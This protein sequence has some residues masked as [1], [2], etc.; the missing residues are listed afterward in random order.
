[1]VKDLP[2]MELFNPQ[3]Y[4]GGSWSYFFLSQCIRQLMQDPTETLDAGTHSTWNVCPS[5]PRP[6]KQS[7]FRPALR[8]MLSLL[9]SSVRTAQGRSVFYSSA[10]SCPSFSPSHYTKGGQYYQLC[11]WSTTDAVCPQFLQLF[12]YVHSVNHFL[13]LQLC[14]ALGIWRC[15]GTCRELPAGSPTVVFREIQDIIVL[16]RVK[17]VRAEEMGVRGGN[18]ILPPSPAPPSKS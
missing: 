5:S 10:A 18:Y 11:R 4:L 13:S 17:D 16:F 14:Q 8:C 1:M 6:E 15:D 7:R 9:S 3:C 2:N 12:L